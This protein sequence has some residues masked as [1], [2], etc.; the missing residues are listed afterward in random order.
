MLRGAIVLSLLMA[1]CAPVLHGG[2][3]VEHWRKDLRSCNTETLAFALIPDFGATK[4]F[5]MNKCMKERGWVKEAARVNGWIWTGPGST[6][7]LTRFADGVAQIVMLC[8]KG[9]TC[10]TV[11][12]VP[13]PA[14]A[15]AWAYE[16]WPKEVSRRLD[17]LIVGD[18]EACEQVRQRDVAKDIPVT[19]ACVGP[20]YFKRVPGPATQ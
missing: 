9:R 6:M 20:R 2:G 3:N 16:A 8:P 14:D 18:Q 15:V 19:G 12:L 13:E 11:T 17:V 10:E 1:G 4:D 7:Q 5:H